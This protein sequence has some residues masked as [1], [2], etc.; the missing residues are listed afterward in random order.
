MGVFKDLNKAFTGYCYGSKPYEEFKTEAINSFKTALDKL[1]GLLGE[2]EWFSGKLSY[3]DF[4]VGDF[5]QVYSLFNENFGTEYPT[6][7]A[8]QER[9]WQLEGINNYLKSDKFKERPINWYP[10]AKWY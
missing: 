4:I 9:L 3:C 10:E 7:K 6:L 1:K 5:F 8:L 2:K